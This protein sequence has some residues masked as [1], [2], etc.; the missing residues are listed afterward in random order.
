MLSTKDFSVQWEGF[1]DVESGIKE[2]YLG[3]GSTNTSTDILDFISV[4]REFAEIKQLD[5]MVDG[6]QYYFILKVIK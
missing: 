2:F 3:V 4:D 6:Y 1:L 5:S